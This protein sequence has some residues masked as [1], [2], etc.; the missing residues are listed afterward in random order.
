MRLKKNNVVVLRVPV[1]RSSCCQSI[2]GITYIFFQGQLI[3]LVHSASDLLIH[4]PQLKVNELSLHTGSLGNKCWIEI[5]WRLTHRS[6]PWLRLKRS[7]LR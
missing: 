3:S 5:P 2:I 1:V 6:L 4:I 7:T